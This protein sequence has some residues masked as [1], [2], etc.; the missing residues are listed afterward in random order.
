[1]PFFSDD[2]I[3]TVIVSVSNWRDQLTGATSLILRDV[4]QER[5]TLVGIERH[6]RA[7]ISVGGVYKY[8]Q[9][10]YTRNGDPRRIRRHGNDSYWA[11]TR[12]SGAGWLQW[13]ALLL[14]MRATRRPQ[15]A[16]PYTNPE[17]RST[18]VA[19]AARLVYRKLPKAGTKGIGGWPWII[20]NSSPSDFLTRRRVFSR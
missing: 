4:S 16:N 3:I 17:D 5:R 13:C 6:F 18:S 9:S 15:T 20:G 8:R 10:L 7:S 14:P 11:I 12:L 19:G 2:I 1:M